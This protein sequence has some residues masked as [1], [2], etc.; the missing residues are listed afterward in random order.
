MTALIAPARARAII[1]VKRES[2]IGIPG[3]AVV[4]RT[5]SPEA[6]SQRGGAVS[7]RVRQ[8]NPVVKSVAAATAIATAAVE[9]Y[10]EQANALPLVA[11]ETLSGH[12]AVYTGAD[13]L[14]HYA[15][16]NDPAS[17]RA[18]LGITKNAA[19][20]GGQVSV[21]IAG[22]VSEPSWSWTPGL[23]I[24]LG[25]NGALT[26]A[27]PASGVVVE[28]GSAVTPTSMNVRIQEPVFLS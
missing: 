18:V 8:Q 23:P 20:E 11:G 3:R 17:A 9:L 19:A 6:V 24:F 26:Q 7:V 4:L 21:V 15:S 13:G 1:R 27:V 5:K 25:A 22:P 14:A 16:A 2:D 12:R 10:R 28:L